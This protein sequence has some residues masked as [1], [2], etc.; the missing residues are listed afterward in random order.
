[1]EFYVLG[2]WSNPYR[3]SD[4]EYFWAREF[5]TRADAVA[6]N[7]RKQERGQPTQF[8]NWVKGSAKYFTDVEKFK[9]A[10]LKAGFTPRLV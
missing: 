2:Y 10:C 1:M 4:K 3:S 5:E 9:A 7:K 8:T 6:Y